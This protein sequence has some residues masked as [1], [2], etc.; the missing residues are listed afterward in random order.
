MDITN[1]L[2]YNVAAS[3]RGHTAKLRQV[4]NKL[5]ILCYYT[6]SVKGFQE[7]YAVFTPNSRSIQEQHEEK[8]L[9][10][11][12]T[13][14]QL[15]LA[16]LLNRENAKGSNIRQFIK[17]HNI[18][19]MAT[20]RNVLNLPGVG[21]SMTFSL[22]GITP[23]GCRLLEFDH[24]STRR[25]SPAIKEMPKVYIKENKSILA[26]LNQLDLMGEDISQYESIWNY[27][28]GQTEHRF[29]LYEYPEQE[30]NIT[31]KYSNL[32]CDTTTNS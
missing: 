13:K 23:D 32:E 25:H 17:E 14:S 9:G 19:F 7:N 22:I 20:D 18:P 30:G 11:L 8:I 12:D 28:E 26:Y 4:L 2:V 29:L 24:D 6:F 16:D 27:T 15:E 31:T 21:K 1:Q 10:K 5:G 3:R